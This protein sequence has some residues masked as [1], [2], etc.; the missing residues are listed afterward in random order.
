MANF[1]W[2]ETNQDWVDL[3]FGKTED[4]A[5][6]WSW[7]DLTKGAKDLLTAYNSVQLQQINIQRAQRGLP[8]LN[9]QQY[10]PQVGV[11]LS[12]STMNTILIAAVGLGAVMLLRRR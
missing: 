7:S 4:A 12:S 10:A 9:P 1:V 3:D 8:A 5:S 2:D 11:N 6:A